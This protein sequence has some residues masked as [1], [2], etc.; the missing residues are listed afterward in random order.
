M[1]LLMLFLDKNQAPVA[2]AGIV[3]PSCTAGRAATRAYQLLTWGQADKSKPTM[4][5]MCS[6]PKLA[7]S[8]ME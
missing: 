7:M 8:A 1:S 3:T 2:G 5:A 4:R 6:Q